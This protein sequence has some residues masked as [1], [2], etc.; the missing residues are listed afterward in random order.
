M[1]GSGDSTGARGKSWFPLESNPDVMNAVRF[2]VNE[3]LRCSETVADGCIG[4]H[5]TST[6]SAF[7]LTHSRMSMY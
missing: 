1:S 4:D 2:S 7:P 5:S 6:N 3:L